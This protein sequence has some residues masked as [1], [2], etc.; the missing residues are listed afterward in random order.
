MENVEDVEKEMEAAMQ[1]NKNDKMDESGK[2]RDTK[3]EDL[4]LDDLENEG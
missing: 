3:E 4:P 1:T 2:D